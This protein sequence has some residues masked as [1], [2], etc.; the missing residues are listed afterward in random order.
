MLSNQI[1]I[2]LCCGWVWPV[3]HYSGVAQ[4]PRDEILKMSLF[5][6]FSWKIDFPGAPRRILERFGALP[7]KIKHTLRSGLKS[8]PR[9]PFWFCLRQRRIGFERFV[10][11][12]CSFRGFHEDCICLSWLFLMTFDWRHHRLYVWA[13]ASVLSWCFVYH[14]SSQHRQKMV[15]LLRLYHV[16]VHD[17]VSWWLWLKNFAAHFSLWSTFMCFEM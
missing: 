4:R 3:C 13:Y 2:E 1:V 16:T 6:D 11:W 8:G 5:G 17:A 7:R 12:N 14:S 10:A 9:S 15:K